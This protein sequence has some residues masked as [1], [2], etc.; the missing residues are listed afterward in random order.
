MRVLM[1]PN[2]DKLSSLASHPRFGLRFPQHE[3]RSLFIQQGFK[4]KVLNFSISEGHLKMP[5][6]N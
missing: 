3:S 5:F 4:G 1:L 6:V 2:S